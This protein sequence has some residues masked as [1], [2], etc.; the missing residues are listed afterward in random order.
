[1]RYPSQGI[2][3]EI[4]FLH[5]FGICSLKSRLLS[6]VMPSSFTDCFGLND[7]TIHVYGYIASCFV[8][9]NLHLSAFILNNFFPNQLTRFLPLFSSL[10]EIS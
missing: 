10:E 5:N 2:D 8:I 9:N 3:F 1:M 6:I 4:D 7:M